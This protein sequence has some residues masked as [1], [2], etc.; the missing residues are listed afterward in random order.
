MLALYS[1]KYSK[2]C[3]YCIRI[4]SSSSLQPFLSPKYL[5]FLK[6]LS[7]H[8]AFPFINQQKQVA[9]NF[10]CTTGLFLIMFMGPMGY[11]YR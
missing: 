4:E 2:K 9:Q 11:K 7:F 1:I 6:Y 3:F 10:Y 8:N 5:S